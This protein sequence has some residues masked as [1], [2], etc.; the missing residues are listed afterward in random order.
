MK[1]RGIHRVTVDDGAELAGHVYGQGP[2]IILIH[3]ALEDGE[4]LWLEVTE[5][6]CDRFTCFLMDMR[7]AGMSDEHPDLSPQRQVRDVVAFAESVGGPVGV[8]GESGGA[9]W[10]L[11]AAAHSEAIAPLLLLHGTRGPLSEWFEESVYHIAN[12][13]DRTRIRTFEGL[14][15]SG[16]KLQPE[17]IAQE[18]RRFFERTLPR[19]ELSQPGAGM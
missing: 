18:L 7:G 14:G 13:V 5:H 2:P 17:V 10:T 4:K 11:G 16:P 19:E 15:H 6:L 1:K 3:G 12:H 9:M 8:F